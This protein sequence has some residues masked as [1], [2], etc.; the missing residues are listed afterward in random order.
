MSN[1]AATAASRNALLRRRSGKRRGVAMVEY[2]FLLT[3]VAIPA[4][5]GFTAGGISMYHHYVQLRNHLLLPT[6]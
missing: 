5:M 4:L 6:P 2:A 3:M 1:V